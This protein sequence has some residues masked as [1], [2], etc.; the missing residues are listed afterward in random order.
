[1][2]ASP[3][4]SPFGSRIPVIRPDVR[5]VLSEP[6][7]PPLAVRRWDAALV[8]V[9]DD[10]RERP[11]TEHSGRGFTNDV[12]LLR[13]DIALALCHSPV[14]VGADRRRGRCRASA[15]W[16]CLA[17]PVVLLVL[18]APVMLLG[19]PLPISAPRA[20]RGVRIAVAT[21]LGLLALLG[22]LSI[23]VFFLP[24]W[25]LMVASAAMS[26]VQAPPVV[27]QLEGGAST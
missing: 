5:I 6:G 8:E 3:T 2:M 22:A 12:S 19:V 24:A 11:P 14:A 17:L 4:T 7:R 21:L 26:N 15:F 27:R 20:A 16:W 1:M 9:D 23:G 13:H 18:A 10:R 25:L